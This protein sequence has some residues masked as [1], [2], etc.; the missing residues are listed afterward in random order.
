M[1]LDFDS[2]MLGLLSSL[3]IVGFILAAVTLALQLRA[4]RNRRN[5]FPLWRITRL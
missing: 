1:I 3:L 5:V 2:F 4:H